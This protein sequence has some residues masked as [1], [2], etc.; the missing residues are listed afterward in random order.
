[1]SVNIIHAG[2]TLGGHIFLMSLNFILMAAGYDILPIDFQ[3]F[4]LDVRTTEAAKREAAWNYRDEDKQK[5]SSDSAVL[6]DITSGGGG[7][8]NM[9]TSHSDW[10]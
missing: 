5:V 3:S 7:G 9:N 8:G 4:P 1:M 10:N 6:F 2:I